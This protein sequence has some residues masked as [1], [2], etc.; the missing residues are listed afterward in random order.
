VA[1]EITQLLLKWGGGDEN[2]LDQLVPLVYDELRQLAGSYLRRHHHQITLQP[3]ALV[4]EAYLRLINQ[5]QVSWENRAQFFGL[6]AKVMRNLLV[7]HVRQKHAAKR[8][9]GQYNV[10]L[11]YAD[12]T[13]NL[14]AGKQPGGKS[15]EVA[16]ID[17][18]AIDEA[19]GRLEG[20]NPQQSRIVELR[21]F[22][23]LTIPEA[24]HVLGVSHATIERD[25][26]VA[27]AWLFCELSK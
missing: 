26:S 3:T 12:E 17:L 15:P 6:A 4:H 2:A 10:S 24:A 7:D 8:G 14:Q 20:I 11:S 22:G 25:W 9:G 16:E 19:L 5:R 1:E 13:V 21:F 27:R 23:G 18:I